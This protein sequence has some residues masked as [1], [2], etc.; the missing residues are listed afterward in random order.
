MVLSFVTNFAR[1]AE[2][3]NWDETKRM[4]SSQIISTRKMEALTGRFGQTHARQE[5]LVT[6]KKHSLLLNTSDY[7]GPDGN[8]D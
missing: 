4:A 5:G 7:F 8:D 3:H 6:Y 1:P 2:N